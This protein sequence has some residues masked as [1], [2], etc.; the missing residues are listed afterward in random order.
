MASNP[1]RETRHYSVAQS[2]TMFR[3]IKETKALNALNEICAAYSRLNDPLQ[4]A[5][6]ALRRCGYTNVYA[7]SVIVP[8]SDKI[9]VGPR[10]LTKEQVLELAERVCGGKR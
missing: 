1:S 8:G 3:R 9:V 10:V 4:L 6:K 2:R 7:E 5:M